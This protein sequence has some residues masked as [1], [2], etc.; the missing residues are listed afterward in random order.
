VG[1]RRTSSG[2]AF[3]TKYREKPR[4][5]AEYLNDALSTNDPVHITKA[6]GGHGARSRCD[7]GFPKKPDL[8]ERTSIDRLEG[9]NQTLVRNDLGCADRARH[10]IDRETVRRRVELG[11]KAKTK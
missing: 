1:K 6:I 10:T 7:E 9:G 4:A 5:I 11:L 3:G 2:E 8:I